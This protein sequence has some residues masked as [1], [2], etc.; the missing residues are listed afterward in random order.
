MKKIEASLIKRLLRIGWQASSF[1]CEHFVNSVLE[2]SHYSL[3]LSY[4][5]IL[6]VF[7]E[8]SWRVWNT[9]DFWSKKEKKEKESTRGHQDQQLQQV[10]LAGIELHVCFPHYFWHA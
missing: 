6:R 1:Q 7:L 5:W 10:F 2:L 4:S 9:W 8:H 3:S